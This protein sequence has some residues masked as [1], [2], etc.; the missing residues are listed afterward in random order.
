MTKV[1]PPLDAPAQPA[2][3]LDDDELPGFGGLRCELGQLPLRSMNVKVSIVG[4]NAVV[5]LR[6]LFRNPA[7]RRAETTYV[8]PLPA[9]AAVARFA[10]TL[11]GRR[12]VGVLRERQVARELYDEA[13]AAGHR[14]GIVEEERPELFTARL[15]NLAPGEEASV[16]LVLVQRLAVADGEATF[17]FPLVVAP[18]YVPGAPVDG[19]PVGDGT[20]LD[21]DAVPDAS[22]VTPP[23][24][25]D[26][27]P[28]PVALSL[29]VDLDPAGLQLADLRCSLHALSAG[30]PEP[31]AAIR[32][33]VHVELVPGEPL[34]RDFLLRVR[35]AGQGLDSAALLVPDA[36]S[37]IDL[38]SATEPPEAKPAAHWRPAAGGHAPPGNTAHAAARLEGDGTFF[39]TLVPPPDAASTAH[40][41]DLIVVLDRSGSMHGWKM[42][43]ARRAAGRIVDALGSADRFALIAFDNAV[44]IFEPSGLRHGAGSARL[45]DATDAVRYRALEWLARLHARGGTELAAALSIALGTVDG[46]GRRAVVVLVTDGQV[47]DEDRLVELA[48]RADRDVRI[49]CVGIDR[50]VNGGLLERLSR[51]AHGHCELVESEER[52]DEVLVALHRRIRSPQLR[53]VTL[54]GAGVE[55]L[56]GTIAPAGVLDVFPGAPLEITGRYR[57]SGAARSPGGGSRV[58]ADDAAEDTEAG[59]T[60]AG[61]T[62]AGDTAAD[63]TAAGDTAAGDTAAGDTAAGDTAAGEI[64]VRASHAEGSPF[65]HRLVPA[66]SDQCWLRAVWARAR[67]RDLEDAYAAHGVE[68]VAT[69]IVATS[70]ATGVLSRH[71]AFLAVDESERL[72]DITADPA[73][74]VQPVPLPSGW[75]PASSLRGGAFAAMMPAV[76]SPAAPA[77]AARRSAPAGRSPAPGGAGSALGDR[78]AP[79]TSDAFGSADAQLPNRGAV[80]G[81]R[82]RLHVSLPDE[83]TDADLLGAAREIARAA[84]SGRLEAPDAGELAA[85]LDAVRRS[86]ARAGR[87]VSALDAALRELVSALGARDRGR[88]ATAAE[89]VVALLEKPARPTPVGGGAGRFWRRPPPASSK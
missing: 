5:E 24:L 54:A 61:D 28:S 36:A 55:L 37:A 16:E 81:A 2:G 13:I 76:A 40:P 68:S 4:L 80:A 23:E 39:V 60:G 20:A 63:D 82:R 7:A 69:E 30:A 43:A 46:S 58:E 10:A 88:I 75:A 25:L 35:M 26:G 1:L 65:E 89:A 84:R 3:A 59:D 64:V 73:R 78:A 27:C 62:A 32:A 50:A 83:P 22:R 52:L 57:R 18:R 85:R 56:C 19:A 67:I 34:D 17:R 86:L 66:V 51:V 42:V 70:L 11:G 41:L 77:R 31:G 72:A 9:R 45:H 12:V 29:A 6:Q 14:A 15:G 79:L 74:L 53:A 38:P 48:E 49:H 33:P 47:A 21:T 71:T 8:F 87:I 44:E